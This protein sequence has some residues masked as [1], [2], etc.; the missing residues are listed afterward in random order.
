MPRRA[1]RVALLLVGCSIGFASPLLGQT[2]RVGLTG[3]ATLIWAETRTYTDAGPG[4]MVKGIS[5]QARSWLVGGYISFEPVP[6]LGLT[7]EVDVVPKGYGGTSPTYSFTYVEV[8]AA[9]DLRPFP[10]GPWSPFLR[11]GL[12][13]G[14]ITECR[15]RSERTVIGPIYG[16]C[17]ELETPWQ[18]DYG[19]RDRDLSAVAGAGVDRRVG[20]LT[21]GFELR[22]SQGL[23]SV[24]TD[25]IFDYNQYAAVLLRVGC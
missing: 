13:P 19:V 15:V 18:D 16:T 17:A 23:W 6:W 25:P 5:G 12:A 9:L 20:P 3:G 10:A 1:L 7:M 8:M 4:E 21:I 22:L 2:L 24:Y 11:I 14:W